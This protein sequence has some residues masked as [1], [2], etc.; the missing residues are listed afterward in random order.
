MIDFEQ[1]MLNQSHI[2]SAEYMLEAV[3]RID[4]LFG[5]GYA[6]NN[7]DLVGTFMKVSCDDFKFALTYHIENRK[8]DVLESK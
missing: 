8:L 3:D 2:T 7:P 6:K 1:Q 5:K 4:A